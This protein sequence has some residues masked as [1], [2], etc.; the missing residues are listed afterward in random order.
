MDFRCR[1]PNPSKVNK[2][3][4][5]KK[6]R[7]EVVREGIY[8]IGAVVN[9]LLA[10]KKSALIPIVEAAAMSTRTPSW[11]E[12][13]KCGR[14]PTNMTSKIIGVLFEIVLAAG[15]VDV[16]GFP[17]GKVL[18]NPSGGVD[19][20]YLDLELKAVSWNAQLSSKEK[21]R[22]ERI[23]GPAHDHL[24]A[25]TN[26]QE[27]KETSPDK[28]TLQLLDIH[29][30]NHA[31][32]ADEKLCTIGRHIRSH[33]R[34]NVMAGKEIVR[35]LA[36][37]VRS[38][39]YTPTLQL[40]AAIG[41]YT[42]KNTRKEQAKI[43]HRTVCD[44]YFAADLTGGMRDLFQAIGNYR[45]DPNIPHLGELCRSLT[46]S[47]IYDSSTRL[48]N[49]REWETFLHSS[50]SGKLGATP[51]PQMHLNAD[52]IIDKAGGPKLPIFAEWDRCFPNGGFDEFRPESASDPHDLWRSLNFQTEKAT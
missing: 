3:L 2:E 6:E 19:L 35:F 44:T 39:E 4:E 18:V 30:L 7:R 52:P 40:L 37:A 45:R 34:E 28:A 36:N 22:L 21:N 27:V 43:I 10:G 47:P 46:E 49:D 5:K 13:I 15:I 20:P 16:G 51:V 1:F 32:V 11:W 33:V 48:P 14:T 17:I 25:I 8:E 26:V 23:L 31:E 29:Y 38:N 50:L 12:D 24:I 42:N 9:R 41:S